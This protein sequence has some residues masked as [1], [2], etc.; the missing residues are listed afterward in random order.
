MYNVST[1]PT[2]S[3]H[4]TYFQFCLFVCFCCFRRQCYYVHSFTCVFARDSIENIPEN[5]IAGSTLLHQI[6]FQSGCTILHNLHHE[7]NNLQKMF[8][9]C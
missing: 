6:V 7:N 3:G 9:K 4:L 2:G 5:G 1:H 8:K